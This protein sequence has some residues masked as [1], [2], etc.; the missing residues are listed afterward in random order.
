[1]QGKW[2][3]A[4]YNGMHNF[5]FRILDPCGSSQTHNHAIGVEPIDNLTCWPFREKGAE[6]GLLAAGH[7]N[8]ETA[9]DFTCSSRGPGDC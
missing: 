4:V 3:V 9:S 1:V 2:A 5:K 7:V 8:V 6:G